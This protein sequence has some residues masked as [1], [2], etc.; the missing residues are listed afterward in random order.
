MEPTVP[1]VT[2]NIDTKPK[3]VFTKLEIMLLAIN[4]FMCGLFLL[5]AFAFFIVTAGFLGPEYEQTF[6]QLIGINKTPAIEDP[7]SDKF[8][9]LTLRRAAEKEQARS[10]RDRTRGTTIDPAATEWE[11][12]QRKANNA[13]QPPKSGVTKVKK[14]GTKQSW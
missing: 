7:S 4:A 3:K 13:P 6:D 8:D 12:A 1:P 14:D 5:T 9:M 11:E 2:V 10:T